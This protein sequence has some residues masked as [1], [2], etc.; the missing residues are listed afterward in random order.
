MY[1]G[2]KLKHFATICLKFDGIL[3]LSMKTDKKKSEKCVEK[4]GLRI[5]LKILNR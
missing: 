5:S 4:V 3:K 1:I 2:S